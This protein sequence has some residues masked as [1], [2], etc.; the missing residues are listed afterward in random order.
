VPPLALCFNLPISTLMSGTETYQLDSADEL[1]AVNHD[2]LHR[3][4]HC[5]GHT[6]AHLSSPQHSSSEYWVLFFFFLFFLNKQ[7]YLFI[8]FM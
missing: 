2:R 4:L 5:S 6:R 1:Q 3:R 8:Y 7:I